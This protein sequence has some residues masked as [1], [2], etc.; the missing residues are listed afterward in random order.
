MKILFAF[1]N[2]LP[3]READAEV[4]L[5]T[6]RHLAP[7]ATRAWLHVPMQGAASGT[8]EVL[9]GVRAWAPLRPAVLRHFCCA[10]TLVLRREFRQADLVYTRNLFVAWTALLCGRR[11]AFDHYRPWP[12]QIPPLQH[13]LYRLLC[14]KRFLVNIC[15][16]QYT[17]AR[18][19]RLGVPAEKLHCV[20]N[21]FDPGLLLAPV[22]VDDAKRAIGIDPAVKT[23]VY[24][25]RLN[26]KKGL[27]LA[28]EAARRLPDILFVLV[29]SYG[30]GPIEDLAA[31]VPNIRIV[32]WQMREDL[33]GYL[34]AADVLM[35][36]P[37]TEPLARFG[38]T[39]L[40][41]KLYLYMAS[42]R[43]IMAGDTADI[44]EVLEHGRN[45]WLCAPDDIE[46]LVA[47]LRRLTGDAELAAAL[48]DHAVADSRT[49]T[50]QARA[51]RIAA[52]LSGR[53]AA[54]PAPEGSWGRAQT[55]NWLR[56]SW[57][58]L[59]GLIRTKSYVLRAETPRSAASRA[60]RL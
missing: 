56:Q 22:A 36:P 24:T 46:A 49:Y 26:H 10:V 31:V 17:L 15:H 47:G 25:G 3:S 40:P 30:T 18:Y 59:A 51:G 21:G 41:L 13:F 43:A 1:E 48:A 20:R 6:A 53:M 55:R 35:I 58:W 7:M 29:G 14:R 28:I 12:E 57:R 44:S 23:V 37:S 52:L 60:A 34:F 42:G 19:L 11:V 54:A 2:P 39:V 4:F 27:A 38:S 8:S 16:S 9:R 45:A 32:P 33:P 5:A 50:W